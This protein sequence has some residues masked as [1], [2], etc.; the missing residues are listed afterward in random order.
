LTDHIPHHYRKGHM[1][2]RPGLLL[3]IV[4]VLLTVGACDQ[5]T[6]TNGGGNPVMLVTMN[7]RTKGAGFTTSPVGNFYRVG[8]ATF[9]S[10]SSASDSCRGTTYDPSEVPAP[11]TATA[12][13]GGAFV[14]ITVSGRTDS[15]RKVSTTDLTYRLATTVGITF[16]PGDSITFLI[17]GDVAGFPGVTIQARTAE[18][19]VLNPVIVP[20]AGQAMTMT[21]TTATDGNAAMLVALRYNNGSGSGLNSQI[22]CDF[23]DD[24]A[25]TVSAALA[26]LWSVST[27]REVFT[28]RLR[29]SLVRISSVNDAFFNMISTYDV[30]TPVSP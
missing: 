28:Q 8:A 20:A 25:G 15:L 19:Y 9:S 24:G 12:I 1:T 13:G 3:C 14:A 29:T 11:I 7:A 23:K 5:L 6:S 26:A 17:P 4:G 22:F 16:V 18:P 27:T 30:P 2:R 10:A 21:W